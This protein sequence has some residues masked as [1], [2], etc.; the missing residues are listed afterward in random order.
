MSDDD[1]VYALV[2]NIDLDLHT[3]DLRNFFA[4]LIES[5]AFV[6]FHYRN[7]PHPSGKFNMCICKMKESRFDDLLKLYN[8]KNWMNR[9]GF[10]KSTQCSIVKIKLAENTSNAP[11]VSKENSE[12]LSESD[13]KT[14]PE[15]QK[16]P[17]WMPQGNV[18]TPSKVFFDLI[19][20]CR[21]PPLMIPKLGLDFSSMKKLRNKSVYKAVQYNYENKSKRKSTY[22]FNSEASES[23]FDNAITASGKE[24]FSENDENG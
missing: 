11:E 6:S 10:V 22:Y 18:G 7:R 14:L 19:T 5:E 24:L 9:E 21:L 23:I 17:S 1:G 13:I 8:K 15:F 20:S 4:R 3:P 16:I 12:L 2:G